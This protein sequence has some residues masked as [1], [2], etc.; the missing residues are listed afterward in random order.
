M[1][2]DIAM[3]AMSMGAMLHGESNVW[4]VIVVRGEGEFQDWR[5]GDGGRG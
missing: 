4:E 2:I 3:M 1:V 5:S